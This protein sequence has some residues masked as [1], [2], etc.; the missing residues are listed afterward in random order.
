MGSILFFLQ[1]VPEV[2]THESYP[3]IYDHEQEMGYLEELLDE[4]EL[5]YLGE[6]S[7]ADNTDH[8]ITNSTASTMDW[9]T[10]CSDTASFDT[11]CLAV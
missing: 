6:Y 7:K 10:L 5:G 8:S 11:C 3:A 1:N 9:L 4:Q 2:L